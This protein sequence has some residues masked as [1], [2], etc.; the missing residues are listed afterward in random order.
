MKKSDIYL[1]L[2]LVV[3][4]IAGCTTVKMFSAT[5][6]VVYINVDGNNIGQYDLYSTDTIEIKKSDKVTNVIVIDNGYVYMKEADCPD[7]VCINQGR[8]C[9]NT[10][11]ICCAPNK[12]IITIDSNEKG[13][14]DAITQ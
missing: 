8:I 9:E 14:F 1:I 2:V 6:N 11:S 5:G 7:K 12:L 10:Q 3:I 13:E 4:G